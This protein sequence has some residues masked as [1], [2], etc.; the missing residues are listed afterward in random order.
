M[1][2]MIEGHSVSEPSAECS[3]ILDRC[4]RRFTIGGSLTDFLAWTA[5]S[6]LTWIIR[7][8]ILITCLHLAISSALSN[9]EVTFLDWRTSGGKAFTVCPVMDHGP[10]RILRQF[11]RF[12]H[13]VAH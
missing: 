12:P 7:C 10:V 8:E 13:M 4:A 9:F 3:L 11:V 6:G 2:V 5:L 1:T